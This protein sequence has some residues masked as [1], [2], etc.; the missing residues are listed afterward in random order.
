MTETQQL[1]AALK[2]ELRVRHLTYRDVAKALGLSEPSV[3]RLFSS[4]RFTLDRLAALT[5]LLGLT[6]AELTL[7]GVASADLSPF[8]IDRP[9]LTDP[10]YEA[11]WLV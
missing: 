2:R 3:K 6:L 4:G 1:L 11:D 7:E 5:G 9:A 10:A 8:R